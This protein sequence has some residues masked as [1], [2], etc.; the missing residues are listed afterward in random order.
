MMDKW[1]GESNVRR[2]INRLMMAITNYYDFLALSK[3]DIINPA[4]DIRV[5]N[6]RHILPQNIIDYEEILNIYQSSEPVTPRDLRNVVMLGFMVFQ[7]LDSGELQKIKVKHIKFRAG[8]IFIPGGEPRPFSRGSCPRELPLDA[9]QLMDLLEYVNNI[10]PAI[11]HR[12]FYSMPGRKPD[13][14]NRVIK[15]DQL[16]LSMTASPNIKN[17]IYYLFRNIQEINP[18]LKSSTQIRQSVITHWLK[19]YDIRKVQYMAGYRYVSSA[20]RYKGGDLE[21]FQQKINKYHPM[22]TFV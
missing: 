2:K 12:K 1:E 17:S 11:L 3:P 8:K 14:E 7:A 16:L 13:K 5:K 10:R 22:K 21:E 4:R 9:S 18:K 15:T 6:S 19:Q 20:E